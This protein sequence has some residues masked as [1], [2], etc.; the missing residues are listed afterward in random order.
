MPRLSPENRRRVI[1]NAAVELSVKNQN[2]H[3]WT[4]EDV[5]G[6]CSVETS[7]ET[8]KHYFPAIDDLRKEAAKDKRTKSCVNVFDRK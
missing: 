8:V 6:A 5:A 7:A 2:I 3:N 4:R 1:V